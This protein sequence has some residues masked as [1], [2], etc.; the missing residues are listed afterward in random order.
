MN[1]VDR[2]GDCDYGYGPD[3]ATAAPTVPGFT[4][5]HPIGS[6][7]FSTVYGAEQPSLNRRVAIKV[8]HLDG[9]NRRQFEHECRTL[10]PLTGVRGILPILQTAFTTDGRPCVVMQ[11]MGRGS[12]ADHIETNGPLSAPDAIWLGG[13][14]AD[15]LAGAHERRIS[16]RDVKPEN[17]LIDDD[18]TV[19]I[20]DFGIGMVEDAAGASQVASAMSPPHAPPERFLGTPGASP[21][22]A[23][24]YSLGST[25]Y[26][27]LTGRPPFGT[28]EQ[29]SIIQLMNRI[30]AEPV[31]PIG[32][33]DVPPALE[34]VICRAMSKDPAARYSSMDEFAAALRHV[35]LDPA[36]PAPSLDAWTPPAG[37]GGAATVASTAAAPRSAAPEPPAAASRIEWDQP[38]PTPAVSAGST[39]A[40]PQLDPEPVTSTTEI[41]SR[42][43]VAI[44][45]AVALL[46]A[47]AVGIGLSVGGDDGT[48]APPTTT[49][50]P[51]DPP[52]FLSKGVGVNPDGVVVISGE[53]PNTSAALAK[54]VV[55]WELRKKGD[56]TQIAGDVLAQAETEDGSRFASPFGPVGPVDYF[57]PGMDASITYCVVLRLRDSLDATQ[58]VLAS[59]EQRCTDGT[60]SDPPPVGGG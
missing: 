60:M 31:P 3:P 18:G 48:A 12:L 14:I 10:G 50:L 23:D 19:A 55:F 1:D 34:E 39:V 5:L 53:N 11:L 51:A 32:R 56:D 4:D 8:L 47:A 24:V 54:S 41:R 38:P 26:H 2:G 46:A 15:A 20:A 13:V 59:S 44:G 52:V 25:L 21:I 57:V 16:H 36:A 33:R 6:G 35:R 43:R 40:R 45:A 17:I 7:G 37:A 42:R 28:V 22:A 27:A 30:V 58:P 49:L 9:P 29:G